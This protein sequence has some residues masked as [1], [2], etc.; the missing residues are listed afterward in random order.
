M[1]LHVLDPSLKCALNVDP[2]NVPL[3]LVYTEIELKSRNVQHA[4]NLFDHATTPPHG[5]ALV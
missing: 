4:W 5:P 2:Q 1:N 3:W